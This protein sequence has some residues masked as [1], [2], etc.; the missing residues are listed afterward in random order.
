MNKI[1]LIGAIMIL[2]IFANG[3]TI[4]SVY[5]L[6]CP[7]DTGITNLTWTGTDYPEPG[8]GYSYFNFTI[9]YYI[10]NPKLYTVR[11]SIP[12][13]NL[14]FMTNITA[15]FVD[16]SLEIYYYPYIGLCA[17]GQ[18]DVKPGITHQTTG[19]I[20]AINETELTILPDGIY[21]LWVF[22]F[23]VSN[24]TFNETILTMDDGT[25]NVTY[26][27]LPSDTIGFQFTSL[28]LLGCIIISTM[29]VDRKRRK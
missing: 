3:Y 24:V 17:L 19:Y 25:A 14:G 28:V 2:I 1:F 26:A 8:E 29:I 12:Y 9:D 13:C 5:A 4:K 16:E 21:T 22:C 20:L 10:H 11:I 7:V 23:G 15:D 27:N 6:D 18:I